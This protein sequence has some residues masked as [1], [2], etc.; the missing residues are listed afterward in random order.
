MEGEK[1]KPQRLLKIYVLMRNVIR[2]MSS[3]LPVLKAIG[4]SI[5]TL[6]PEFPSGEHKFQ[7]MRVQINACPR[8]PQRYPVMGFNL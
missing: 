3:L 8:S 5:G 4:N 7:F 2:P 6:Q 1:M